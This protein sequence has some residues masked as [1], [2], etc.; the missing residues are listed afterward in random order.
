MS[1]KN[2]YIKFDLPD[3]IISEIWE[4]GQE[5]ATSLGTHFS[6]YE[7]QEIHMTVCFLGNLSKNLG[8]DS[9]K[10][11]KYIEIDQMIDDFN[12]V[13]VKGITFLE[14]QLF[15]QR[16]NLLVAVFDMNKEDKDRILAFKQQFVR[17][18]APNENY[19]TPHITVGKILFG[20]Q[21]DDISDMPIIMCDEP[22]TNLVTIMSS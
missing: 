3:T 4:V 16:K 10:K 20:K 12:K 18:G 15:G 8:T 2:K 13:P 7:K 6:P 17:F 22:I 21:I 14:Y 11:Q 5:I 9:N 1:N 19:F